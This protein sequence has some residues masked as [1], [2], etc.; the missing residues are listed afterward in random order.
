MSEV[1]NAELMRRIDHLDAQIRKL[2]R[3]EIGLVVTAISLTI[4]AL[5]LVA[6]TLRVVSVPS[7]QA[8]A[9]ISCTGDLKANA[10][11][12]LEPSIGGYKVNINC[13]D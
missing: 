10:W 4:I 7:A 5:C 9:L 12:G 1:G 11:G 2:N 3:R 6:L 8:R 13:S